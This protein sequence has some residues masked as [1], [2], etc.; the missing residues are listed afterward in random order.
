MSYID[1][2][3]LKFRLRIAF[4][5]DISTDP[6]SWPWVDV[7]EWLHI[8]AGIE[9]VWGYSSGSGQIESSQLDLTLKNDG[10]FS[11]YN[12]MSPYWP[13]VIEW[14]PIDF[15]VDLGDGEG[16]R[17]RFEGFVR[18]W[19]TELVGNSSRMVLSPISC[20][21]VVA[22]MGRGEP[23]AQS[24]LYRSIRWQAAAYWPMEEGASATLA[25]SAFAGHAPLTRLGGSGTP[26]FVEVSTATW[27]TEPSYG[28]GRLADISGGVSLSA[29]LD[30]GV[31]ATLD[32]DFS[33]LIHCQLIDP[34]TLDDSLTLIEVETAGGSFV[35]WRLEMHTD[36]GHYGERIVA[37]DSGGTG[38]EVA[39]A[40]GITTNAFQGYSLCLWQDGGTIRAGYNWHPLFAD[41]MAEG[42]TSGTL[43]R[44]IRITINPTRTSSSDPVP[45]GH[46]ALF[47]GHPEPIHP[48]TQ[49]PTQPETRPYG[50]YRS[51]ERE[52][53]QDRVRRLGLEDGIPITVPELPDGQQT[54]LMWS[55]QIST[56][57]GLYQECADSDGALLYEGGFGLVV[58]PRVLRYN[59]EVALTVDASARE[60]ALPFVPVGDDQIS[61]NRVVVEQIKGA[62][63]VAEDAS[64]VARQGA[65]TRKIDVSLTTG[66]DLQSHAEWWLHLLRPTEARYSELSIKLSE[67]RHLA[68]D[69]VACR[70][71]SRM[72]VINS[73]LGGQVIDQL[74]MGARE[75]FAGR[76]GWKVVLNVE[77]A[78]PWM[79]AVADGE[80]RVAAAGSLLAVDAAAGAPTFALYST[81]ENG[82]WVTDST[83]F[84]FDVRLGGE[85][86]TATSI[87]PFALDNFNRVETNRW[88]TMPTG[89]TWTHLGSASAFRTAAG[90]GY[91]LHTTV[92]TGRHS[93]IDIGTG[94]SRFRFAV[95]APV[96]ATG[97]P[98]SAYAV[99]RI[100]PASPTA[101]Q[102]HV[103]CAFLT[104]GRVTCTVRKRL[105]GDPDSKSNVDLRF[106]YTPGAYY[107]VEID[108]AGS[109]IRGRVYPVNAQRPPAWQT[110]WTDP[111][112]LP[113]TWT[114]IG[115][116]TLT[117]P[118][119]TN[120]H[121]IE[122]PITAFEVFSPQIV[123]A[124]RG[125]NGVQ[126]AWQA[127]TPVN[128]WRPAVVPL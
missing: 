6:D 66:S 119:S 39:F 113:E 120:T 1:G 110:A 73:P 51:Y 125:V 92:D 101:N 85:R 82:P 108:T 55:Q 122:Y 63:A 19:P 53:M 20:V 56:P 44:P 81:A 62:S 104:D 80:R 7:T 59:P 37:Y 50:A 15:A 52:P 30:A 77:P 87:G 102:Y 32:G 31:G 124:T 25:G 128:V 105:A 126:R 76:R 48:Q 71:G 21:G 117:E 72:Q 97:M 57:M 5:A 94:N 22:R 18:S 41:W 35:R 107:Y 86:V 17:P 13:N 60:L 123:T 106:S 8:P 118:G 40:A 29:R 78:S 61:R 28:T 45:V 83:W 88:G 121:P 23:P 111:D 33:A 64:L 89:Q 9:H 67:A 27:A 12:A 91:H 116:T 11:A 24:P 49:S 26:E 127:G 112:P 2:D 103:R 46:L 65:I 79:V 43:G 68:A 38:T 90:V 70:P 96:A 36:P 74:I 10:R 98:L 100:D 75:T 47:R 84:P 42:S 34:N 4:G 93:I 14:T 54:V 95:A 16:W 69:Y 58:L 109:T 3:S 99:S 114:Q 115:I